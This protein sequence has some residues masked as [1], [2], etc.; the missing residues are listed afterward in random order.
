MCWHFSSWTRQKTIIMPK[1]SH[2]NQLCL[3][4]IN[5]PYNFDYAF[6]CYTLPDSV[7]FN[8]LF[9]N[10]C[11]MSGL[12]VSLI[13]KDLSLVF[14]GDFSLSSSDQQFYSFSSYFTAKLQWSKQHGVAPTYS[15]WPEFASPLATVARTFDD[16]GKYLSF[17][18]LV[19][20]N[21]LKKNKAKSWI[22]KGQAYFRD[23]VIDH[24]WCSWI[25]MYWKTVLWIVIEVHSVKPEL[26]KF[27]IIYRLIEDQSKKINS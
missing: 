13:N 26:P 22:K 27:S 14:Y 2:C 7:I 6:L 19:R 20:E 25:V 11:T 4:A 8:L 15:F 18:C 24:F 1:V 12:I 5:L 10:R 3:N 23:A 17:C 21:V 16:K 9:Q